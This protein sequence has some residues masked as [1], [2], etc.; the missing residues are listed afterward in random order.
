MKRIVH[1]FCVVLISA[2]LTG[3]KKPTEWEPTTHAFTDDLE[4]VTIT[5]LEEKVTPAKGEIIIKN[6]SDITYTYGEHF[7]IEKNIQGD[8]YQLPVRTG[9]HQFPDKIH[10][11]KATE[12]DEWVIEW[13]L[14]YGKLERGTYRII[15]GVSAENH[16]EG[17]ETHYVT[18]EF[19][20]E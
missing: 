10:Q 3:C 15:K 6:E 7:M 1:L 18:A 9:D 16:V 20:I 11:L 17:Y 13:S 8:W 2:A 5:L 12:S 19:A 4:G 14:L